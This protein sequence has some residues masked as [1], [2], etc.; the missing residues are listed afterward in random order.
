MVLDARSFENE[1]TVADTSSMTG[2]QV[3]S[4]GGARQNFTAAKIILQQ[5]FLL[6]GAIQSPSPVEQGSRPNE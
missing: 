5:D 6:A 1:W 2:G 3:I 4:V